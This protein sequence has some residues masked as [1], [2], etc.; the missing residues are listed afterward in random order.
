MTV[1]NPTHLLVFAESSGST[2]TNYGSHA[3]DWAIQAGTEN[4]HYQWFPGA[5]PAYLDVSQ[6]TGSSLPR[7]ETTGTAPS[8][9]LTNINVAIGFRVDSFDTT[10]GINASWLVVED[11]G[12]RIIVRSPAGSGDFDLEIRFRDTGDFG[13]VNTISALTFGTDYRVA[14]SIDVSDPN[15]CQ[16]RYKIGG[17][18]TVTPATEG[19]NGLTWS[20]AFVE[21][22]HATGFD[23]YGGLDGR[24]HYFAYERG[25]TVWSSSDLGDI[26]SNPAGT[27]T[28]W[29]GGGSLALTVENASLT[30]AGQAIV[31]DSNLVVAEASVAITGQ[32]LTFV[33]SAG[34]AVDEATLTVSGQNVDLIANSNFVLPVVNATITS[35]GQEVPFILDVPWDEVSLSLTGQDITLTAGV[36]VSLTVDTGALTVAGQTINLV[37]DED[38]SLTVENASLA[39]AGQNVTL[40]ALTSFVLDI[41]TASLSFSSQDVGLFTPYVTGTGGGRKCRDRT[42]TRLLNFGR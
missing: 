34:I 14:A 13:D 4:T 7:I 39:L 8:A 35:E 29:P 24:L 11:A 23:I 31:F 42:A 16:V 5:S 37:V 33:E 22:N 15:N 27:I 21:L 3:N 40:D 28:G 17:S 25:G 41:T 38:F 6:K 10:G 20:N 12:A 36:P 1:A 18:S 2:V 19:H 26:N 30:G 32:T 9:S